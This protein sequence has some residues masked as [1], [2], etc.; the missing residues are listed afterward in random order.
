MDEVAHVWDM[1]TRQD[2]ELIE[3]TQGGLG[4]RRYTPGLLSANHEPYIRSS[5]NIYLAMMAG[6]PRAAELLR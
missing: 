4:S 1:T 3:R 6:D 5:L 2:V